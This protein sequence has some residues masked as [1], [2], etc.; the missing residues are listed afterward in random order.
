MRQETP[1]AIHVQ[2]FI[3]NGSEE[4]SVE[5]TSSGFYYVRNG[6]TYLSYHEE[7]DLGKIKTVVKITEKEILVMRSG[8]IQMKQR[9]IPGASTLT[10]YKLPFGQMELRTETKNIQSD[11]GSSEGSVKLTYNMTVG[12]N[13]EHVHNMTIQYKEETKA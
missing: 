6:K 4:E 1:V 9:F 13:Q 8:A 10:Q 12:E 3:H 7:H 11:V 5:F 2:S